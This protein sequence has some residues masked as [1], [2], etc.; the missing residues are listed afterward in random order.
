VP[1][2][3]WA[4]AWIAVVICG[5]RYLIDYARMR[6]KLYNIAK[7]V[8]K[9]TVSK[10]GQ[11]QLIEDKIN[12]TRFFPLLCDCVSL[13]PLARTRKELMI[14]IEERWER[15]YRVLLLK[16]SL[17]F[18]HGHDSKNDANNNN[19][20]INRGKQ[21]DRSEKAA[22]EPSSRI[23]EITKEWSD[24]DWIRVFRSNIDVR[25][26]ASYLML[27]L[28]RDQHKYQLSSPPRMCSII[29]AKLQ[30]LWPSFLELPRS[31]II[32]IGNKANVGENTHSN[33][34][35][36]YDISLI[37]PMYKERITD[38]G[39]TLN[40]AFVSCRDDPKKIQ[41]IVVHAESNPNNITAALV[42]DDNTKGSSD[43]SLLRQQL[44]L[45]QKQQQQQIL[46]LSK[47]Q[48]DT[49]NE[50]IL[51]GE[52]KVVTIPFG[53]G[54]GRGRTLNVGAGRATAPILSFLHADTIMPV[55]WDVQIK[56][57][58]RLKPPSL[59]RETK[60]EAAKNRHQYYKSE[61]SNEKYFFHAC[62]FTM[63]IDDGTEPSSNQTMKPP[64]QLKTPGLLGVE[65]LGIVRCRC[66][67]PYGDS[68]LSFSRPM[69]DYM[70]GYPDQP[71]MEDY[72]VM[73]WLRLRGILLSTIYKM[74]ATTMGTTNSNKNNVVGASRGEGLALLKDRA[75]CS[76]RRWTKY[77]CAYTCL[78]NAICIFRYHSNA[79]AEELFDF[80]YHCNSGNKK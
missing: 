41:V 11:Q 29:L 44:L 46:K 19:T 48:L 73:D 17:L 31:V 37:I 7:N 63:A 43:N 64:S 51:W 78:V 6:W 39:N 71:L 74:I 32:G 13:C 38:V 9:S 79:T 24:V 65:W 45:Q 1:I 2:L 3:E 36:A 53:K 33:M 14:G 68:V 75:K 42:G 40:R 22:A 80:Y 8:V 15:L 54:G 4:L 28:S 59:F 25:R 62:A 26:E 57:A 5:L 55:G 10:S 21:G 60:G 58:L 18:V 35:P 23:V 72:E 50:P 69:F 61:A 52:L 56:E 76:S 12:T 27:A 49:T 66:G 16:S 47:K 70:G 34:D 77:G 67:L 20:N 30:R